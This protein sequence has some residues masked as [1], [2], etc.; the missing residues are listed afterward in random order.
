MKYA[1]FE[2]K[3][4][5]LSQME[6]LT[7]TIRTLGSLLIEKGIITEEETV[8]RFLADIPAPKN[9]KPRKSKK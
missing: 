5:H 9:K 4:A 7:L 2:K 8:K 6:I 1:D 3:I